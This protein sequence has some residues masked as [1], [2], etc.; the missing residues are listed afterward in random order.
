[1]SMTAMRGARW[2]SGAGA[3]P[4]A[5]AVAAAPRAR[6]ARNVDVLIMSSPW[7]SGH[8]EGGSDRELERALRLEGVALG[9][10]GVDETERHVQHRHDETQLGAGGRAQLIDR[11]GLAIGVGLPG[12]VEEQEAQG[13]ADVDVVLGVEEDEL[14]AAQGAVLDVEGA[15]GAH[16]VTADLRLPPQ[17]EPLVVGQEQGV[18]E[19]LDEGEL[20]AHA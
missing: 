3:A 1:M 4:W 20:P 2:A 15:H 9:V 19:R 12:V 16:V 18:P 8:L 5:P 11:D 10:P 6:A 7:K 14:V 17:E 13:A